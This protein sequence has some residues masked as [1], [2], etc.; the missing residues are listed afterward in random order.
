MRFKKTHFNIAQKM[1]FIR[2]TCF[3]IS[4]TK[5]AFQNYYCKDI[6]ISPFINVIKGKNDINNIK[7]LKY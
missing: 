5:N 2:K 4:P 1:C 7:I 3:K 6:F